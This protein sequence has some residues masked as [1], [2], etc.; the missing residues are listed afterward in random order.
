ML[1]CRLHHGRS[2]AVTHRQDAVREVLRCS[3]ANRLDDLGIGLA[4]AEAEPDS[5]RDAHR[6][7]TR[8]AADEALEQLTAIDALHLQRIGEHRRADHS[9]ARHH[10]VDGERIAQAVGLKGR[11]IQ[12]DIDQIRLHQ[13]PIDLVD[14]QKLA[15]HPCQELLKAVPAVG[16]QLLAGQLLPHQCVDLAQVLLE[17]LDLAGLKPL[18]HYRVARRLLQQL[19]VRLRQVCRWHRLYPG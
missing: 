5:V 3:P 2:I 19:A 16:G 9:V 14:V 13:V 17:L 1:N 6:L 4:L 15:V 8:P 11:L 10:S 7:G 18:Q 12:R